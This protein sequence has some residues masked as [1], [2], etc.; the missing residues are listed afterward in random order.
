MKSILLVAGA[1]ICLTNLSAQWHKP[2]AEFTSEHRYPLH[3]DY[4]AQPNGSVQQDYR[5]GSN[6]L[7]LTGQWRFSWVK[8]ANNRPSEFYKTSYDDKSWSYIAV[9]GIW[10]MNGYGDPLYANEPYPW[11]NQFKN[12]P[13]YIP[14]QNNHVGSYRRTIRIPKSWAGHQILFH[15]G[16]V[17]S[18]LR[19]WVNGKYVGYSE[20]SKLPA[21]FDLSAYVKPGEDALIAMQVDRWSTGTYLESQDFWR[22]SGIAR[23]IYLYARSPKR[24]ENFKITQSLDE[25]NTTGILGI[26][27]SKKG[28]FVTELSLSDAEGKVVYSSNVPTGQSYVE[29]KLSNVH[30]W[31]AETPYLYTLKLKTADETIIEQVGFRRIEIKNSQLLVNGKPILIKGVNRHEI[32]PDG[33]YLVSRER[34]EQDVRIMKEL[35]INAVRTCHYPDDS[36]FYELCDKYGLYVVSEANVESHGMGQAKASLSHR[37]EWKHAHVERNERQVAWLGNHPSIIIW[38]LG[39]E[40]G[41]GENFGHA[42]SAVKALDKTRPVQYENAGLNY[43]DIYCRMYRQPHELLKYIEEGHKKPFIL[44]EYAHAMGNS[45][46]GFDEYWALFRKHPIL[47]G[48]FI[49]D[50]VDQGL[51]AYDKQG[52]MYY[53]YAGDYNKYDYKVDNNFCNNGIVSPDRRYNPHAYEV[54]YQHQNIWS[55]L[56]VD[57][58]IRNE[59]FF[60]DLSAYQLEWTLRLNGKAVQQGVKELPPIA[61]QSEGRLSLKEVFDHLPE[62]KKH[63]VLTLDLAYK[64]KAEDGLLPAGY[65][66]AHQQFVFDE[67]LKSLPTKAVDAYAPQ[68]LKVDERDNRY[69]IVEGERLRLDIDRLTGLISRYSVDGHELLEDGR[70]ISPNFWRAAT[71]NDM[72]AWLQQKYQL[73]RNPEYK[74]DRVSI[75]SKSSDKVVLETIW[76]MPKLNAKLNIEYVIYSDGGI[77]YSQTFVPVDGEKKDMPNL[78]RYGIRLGMPKAYNTVEYFGYGPEENYPDRATSQ[79]LGL[80]RAKVA[81][82]YYPYVRPQET[83]ARTGLRYYKVVT[84]GGRGLE[85]RAEDT[86]QA[87]ALEYSLESLDGFPRKSQQHG[88]TVDK[89]GY[90]DVL[91]DAYHMGLGCYNSWGALPQKKF[92]LPYG[93]YTMTLHLQPIR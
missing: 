41:P 44:C 74:V 54:A 11:H 30:A 52:R 93:K 45:M 47:Q 65:T 82:L 58:F 21:V 19:L 57:L 2:N 80:Y 83:G 66:V 9:P 39:N 22:L 37:P 4:F 10:E 67:T 79:Q 49:W 87:S 68:D 55:R 89:C 76:T 85:V 90:T 5:L 72:G 70:Q 3:A 28:S 51:R 26:S 69:L 7:S 40:S 36:Y 12:N 53:S 1:T 86:F 32:D 17:T 73:W 34:M 56:D 78:F 14:E 33:G 91:I 18:A 46:G 84:E 43:T 61:P 71:D 15:A 88:W 25:D 35:N 42:Y 16:S 29:T 6:Y 59:Y 8:D 50:F 48:G 92:Q 23:D 63:D 64:L 13:P 24:I 62:T 75:K 60:R 31:T 27:L 77:T 20:D 81:D 38:S